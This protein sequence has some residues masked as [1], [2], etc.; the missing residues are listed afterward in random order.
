MDIQSITLFMVLVAA[1][2]SAIWNINVKKSDN[3]L[4]FVTLMVIPQ[5]LV[6]LPL[7]FL[8]PMPSL[9]NLYYI[10]ASAFVQTGYIV[11]LSTAYKHGL[12]SRVYPL[13]VGTATLLSLF[14]WHFFLA[15]PLSF[16][17][18][19]GVLLLSFGIICFAF[20]GKRNNE[21]LS[22]K[23]MVYAFACSCFIFSYSLIDTF[24]IHTATKPLTYISWLFFIKAL[25]LF[26]PMLCLHPI[27]MR[28]M[29]VESN[30]YFFAGLLAGF[31]Y[32]VAIWAFNHAATPIVLALR[33]TSIIF[34]L[35]L[36]LFHL[37]EQV[38]PIIVVLTIATTLGAFFIL[39]F[40]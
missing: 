26:I 30:N 24:G 40:S 38:S 8:N 17:K 9:I 20:I 12:V 14:F 6:S 18:E 34:V 2:G 7:M 37:K 5:F 16:Y 22:V 21:H 13:A 35:L 31:G 29:A 10:L 27:S 33:S 32:G 11:F 1:F 15:T 25:I 23:G 28:T 36:S 3:G 4:V 19:F 39:G